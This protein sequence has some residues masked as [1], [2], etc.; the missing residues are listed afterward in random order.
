MGVAKYG[1]ILAACIRHQP[2]HEVS[3]RGSAEDTCTIVF[4]CVD[5][6]ILFPWQRPI[7]TQM[8][9]LKTIL[10]TVTEPDFYHALAA[11]TISLKILYAMF[12]ALILIYDVREELWWVFSLFFHIFYDCSW[13]PWIS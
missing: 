9:A 2:R 12:M 11:N 10:S 8:N 1:Q 3:Y 6:P 13:R 5:G 4:E 7:D